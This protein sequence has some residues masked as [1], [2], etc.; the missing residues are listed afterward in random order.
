[1]AVEVRP[2]NRAGQRLAPTTLPAG[3]PWS[4]CR[5]VVVR[6]SVENSIE[7]DTPAS[8]I[9]ALALGPEVYLRVAVDGVEQP[10]WY[11]LEDDGD[12]PTDE[13][14]PVRPLTTGGRGA[15]AILGWG[16]VYPQAHVAGQP[17]AGLDPIFQ[18]ANASVGQIVTTLVDKAK[19]RGCFPH[20]TLGFSATLDSAGVAWPVDQRYSISYDA[21]MSLLTVVQNMLDDAWCDAEMVGFRLDLYAPDTALAADHPQTV[22]RLGR[23]VKSAP[24]KRTRR[25]V[26][27]T[28]LG[29]GDE[30]A[31]VE[32]SDP[33]ALAKYGRRE[34]YEGRGG[35]TD[36]GVLA[37]VT[38]TSLQ[39]QTD[40]SEA[41]TLDLEPS[42]TPTLPRPG[43]Y[44]RY[45]QRRQSTNLLEPLRVQSIAWEYGD[46]P[47]LSVELMDL[48]MDR[49]VRIARRLEALTR[50]SG[51]N[52]R[53]PTSRPPI[54]D[55]GIAPLAPGGVSVTPFV[56]YPHRYT[57]VSGLAP[58]SAAVVSWPPVTQNT[59][60]TP[61]ND[62]GR[63]VVG[64]LMT[65]RPGATW[66]AERASQT[67]S[68]QWS[69]FAFG[70]NVQFRVA[71]EDQDGNRSGWQYS[72]VTT[73]TAAA[74]P[75]PDAPNPTVSARLG[76]VFVEWNGLTDAGATPPNYVIGAEVHVST[77][78]GFTPSS[79]TQRGLT[80]SASIPV[81]VPGLPLGTTQYVKI[82]L[83]DFAG[84][85]GLASDAIAV[86][87]QPLVTADMLDGAVGTAKLANLAVTNAKIADLSINDA[88]I[89][90]VSAGKIT[91]GTLFADVI[92][93]GAIQTAGSGARTTLSASGF[94]AYNA[95][96]QVTVRIETNGNAAFAGTIT[97]AEVTGYLRTVSSGGAQIVLRPDGIADPSGALVP[98][99]ILATGTS[100]ELAPGA[101]YAYSSTYATGKRWMHSVMRS[102]V[103]STFGSQYSFIRCSVVGKTGGY[104]TPEYVPAEVVLGFG[105]GSTI[106]AV[107][108]LTSTLDTSTSAPGF[109]F[110]GNSTSVGLRSLNNMLDVVNSTG[111]AWATI[112]AA[113]FPVQSGAASKVGIRP[114]DEVDA[115]AIIRDNPSMLWTY[116]QDVVA[117]GGRLRIGPVADGLPE[118]LVQRDADGR[119]WMDGTG[120]GGLLWRA[121]HQLA[122][123]AR[124]LPA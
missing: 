13:G 4:A 39:R 52:E 16:T 105:D 42:A 79:A 97:A 7:V 9:D 86:T 89:V 68:V 60:G 55:D 21:G 56:Y 57:T 59:D 65:D 108:N 14:G 95:S 11:V 78:P 61:F 119:Y 101:V 3:L 20:L 98:A 54:E 120:V 30:G 28:L 24:R 6:N 49:D 72:P 69:G 118:L 5:R 19:A 96:N 63:Y 26:V 76:Q 48:W 83:V 38:T 85:R 2:Y 40:A 123:R 75:I 81:L 73:L 99:M 70:E 122:T 87:P 36:I 113:S 92:L 33:D 90:S 104:S 111:T 44:V 109:S 31:M 8:L 10:D 117:D 112:R 15:M 1:M 88:K 27:S 45:D 23:E 102:P 74:G 121:V 35:M 46:D 32:V 58:Q 124:R 37:A 107:P 34:G 116:D 110:R 67:N 93:S 51:S 25:S 12:D 50:G 106:A 103:V 29:G 77:D 100:G 53:V 43:A 82:V 47:T 115:L 80:A 84:T 91:T 22:L 17:V 41:L 62:F 66:S 114:A 94:F 18:F 71:A 64:M